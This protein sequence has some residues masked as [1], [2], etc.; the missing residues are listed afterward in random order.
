MAFERVEL[1]GIWFAN[2]TFEEVCAAID[3]R[4]GKGEPGFI[5]TPN[6]DHVCRCATDPAFRE[7]YSKA[8]LAL[9]DGMPLL[10][11]CRLLGRPL[12]QKLSGSDLVPALSGYAAERGYSI[13]LLGAAQGVAEAAA[14][15][16]SERWPSLRIAG[17]YS[18]PLGF[19]ADEEENAA[20]VNRVREAK[21]D[22]CFVALG[23]P[24]QEIWM[25][26]NVRECGTPVLIGIGAGIDFAAGR[27]RRAP[28]WMQNWGLEWVWRLCHEPRRLWRRYLIADLLFFAIFWREFRKR[29]ARH[30]A[31][32][33]DL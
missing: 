7:A 3:Q 17:V 26:G 32:R 18:P 28:R 16:L 20:T 2:V 24:H 25:S 15:R 33:K 5:V 29:F 11:A 1:L 14:K 13:F 30:R 19:Y 6:V 23:A 10:W 12:W 22:I 8:F 21:A 4:I 31:E 27:K 9:A